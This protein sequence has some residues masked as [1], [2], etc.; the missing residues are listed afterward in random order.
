[1]KI[2]Y[3]A[4][5]EILSTRFEEQMK[6][7]SERSRINGIRFST[8]KIPAVRRGRKKRD[9]LQ[10][11]ECAFMV[12]TNDKNQ[13]SRKPAKN[14]SIKELMMLAEAQQKRESSLYERSCCA[15]CCAL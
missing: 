11:L 13:S 7:N 4:A 9:I 6:K 1:M 5:T 14:Y 15:L 8:I 3:L 2:N 12:S 10:C